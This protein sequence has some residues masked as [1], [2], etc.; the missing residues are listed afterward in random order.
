[1][2]KLLLIGITMLLLTSCLKKKNTR[3]N[4][5]A[6]NPTPEILSEPDGY[7]S[8]RYKE[9]IITELFQDAIKK[10]AE[11]EA[12]VKK[13][14]NL[15]DWERSKLE[16]YNKFT[17]NYREYWAASRYLLDDIK[18]ST[19][20]KQYK[21]LFADLK[22]KQL[23]LTYEIDTATSIMNK[24]QQLFNDYFILVK[25][26]VTQQ[27]MQNYQQNELP[28]VKPIKEVIEEYDSLISVSKS[29]IQKK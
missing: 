7:I 3:N 24:K 18:D 25:L 21:Q 1:M 26:I 12:Y 23:Q 6:D 29:I 2:R 4:Q 16:D 27:M 17:S 20:K 22:T 15:G 9:D 14:E 11:L 5:V 28:Q 13:H 8:K 10:D 19:L